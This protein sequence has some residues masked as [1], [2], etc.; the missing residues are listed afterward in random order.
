MKKDQKSN[1]WQ[2]ICYQSLLIATTLGLQ[3]FCVVMWWLMFLW[4]GR[5][6]CTVNQALISLTIIAI[7]FLNAVSV[8]AERGSLFVASIVSVYGTYLCYSGL[9]SNPDSCNRFPG[10]K[11]TLSLWIGIVITA[12]A[13]SYAG[14][15]VSSSTGRALIGRHSVEEVSEERQMKPN[16]QNKTE[17]IEVNEI[18]GKNDAVEKEPMAR[19][20]YDDLEDNSKANK[21]GKNQKQAISDDD[22]AERNRNVVFHVCM[23]LAAIYYAML[24]TNWA[25]DSE[26]KSTRSGRG[27]ISLIINI[28]SEWLSFVLYLW[29]LFAP[30]IF[31]N[32]VFD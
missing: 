27:N 19:S 15:S 17:E 20:N 23:A 31:P 4:F 7:V 13:L 1:K 18:E 30:K 10:E 9:Q 26:S 21:S 2:I 16:D 25:T 12:A 29:T 3:A 5:S 8:Y 11:N 28:S 24:Y 32:R 6:G 14:F 22:K